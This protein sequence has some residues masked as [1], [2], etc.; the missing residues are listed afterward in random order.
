MGPSGAFETTWLSYALLRDNFAHHV[1]RPE[2]LPGDG[3]ALIMAA[4]ALGGLK[5]S[6]SAEELRRQI[7]QM[8][9]LRHLPITQLAIGDRT[10]AVIA[11][12]WP[13]P[14]QNATT[15]VTDLAALE[16]VPRN[17]HVLGEVF[18]NVIDALLAIPQGE[19]TPGARVDVLD[20]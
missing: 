10:R 8:S 20:T 5:V 4:K 14:E 3:G 19:L 17:A 18:G 11:R 15:L 2:G 13:L 7:M 16:G 9:A 1:Q 6:V 12:R